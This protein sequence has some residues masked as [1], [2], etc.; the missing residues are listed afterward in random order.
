M[1][2]NCLG[3]PAQCRAAVSTER[4]IA[5]LRQVYRR[6][7]IGDWSWRADMYADD[8]EWGWSPEFPDIAGVYRD[9]ETP[10]RRLLT[11]LAPWE[12]WYCS[13]E[14]YITFGNTIVVLTRYRGRGKGSGLVVDVEGA[15]VWTF[16]GRKAVR[17]E[18]FADRAVAFESISQLAAA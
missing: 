12:K 2:S 15:H 10:N 14:E 13:A 11:W 9:T 17:L 8:M 7:S 3:R 18:V 16:R 5:S 4:V 1:G 6:W